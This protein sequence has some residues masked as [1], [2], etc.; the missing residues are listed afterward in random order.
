MVRTLNLGQN[1]CT[2]RTLKEMCKI[3]STNLVEKSAH[4]LLVVKSSTPFALKIKIMRF[5]V[6]FVSLYSRDN[7]R[8]ALFIYLSVF[9]QLLTFLSH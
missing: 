6:N 5:Y 9:Y 8:L 2:L 3:Q 1:F 4:F 7:Y